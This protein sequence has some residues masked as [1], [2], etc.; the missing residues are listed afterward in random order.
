MGASRFAGPSLLIGALLATPLTVF[1]EPPAGESAGQ[2]PTAQSLKQEIDQLKQD[3]NARLAALESRLAAIEGGTAWSGSGRG[4][5]ANA[6]DRG[7]AAGCAG[8]RR[9][10][11]SA[12]GVRQRVCG[13]EDLQP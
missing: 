5:A 1:A 9:T 10:E 12:S 7:S 13:V 3:F 11:R 8:R 4:G 2:E 6:T